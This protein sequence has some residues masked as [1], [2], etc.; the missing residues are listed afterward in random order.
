M[1]CIEENK[2][3]DFERLYE[4]EQWEKLKMLLTENAEE[5]SCL[6]T[7]GELRQMMETSGRPQNEDGPMYYYLWGLAQIRSDD[8]VCFRE[9]MRMIN[10]RYRFMPAGKEKHDWIE[11]YLNLLYENPECSIL[12]WVDTAEKYVSI[13]GRIRLY[14]MA[15]NRPG[16]CF[17]IK[18]M[19]ALFLKDKWGGGYYTA[20][21]R[22]IFGA[23]ERRLF[24]MAEIEYRLE[25]NGEE[26]V[27]GELNEIFM[28]VDRKNGTADEWQV[29]IRCCCA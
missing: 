27:E 6:L 4:Q 7:P 13:V 18:E 10:T 28:S 23:V 19:S 14:S 21:W 22:R 17:G 2:K 20:C 11:V 15:G 26:T 24:K 16:I 8:R 12:D 9:T 29:D 25:T 5:V 1:C 3:R